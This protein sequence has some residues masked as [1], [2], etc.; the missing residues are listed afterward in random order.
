[1]E[2]IRTN[3]RNWFNRKVNIGNVK[4]KFDKEGLAE[5]EQP[6]RFIKRFPE[7]IFLP[8]NYKEVEG[9]K[10]LTQDE[11]FKS[12]KEMKEA[13]KRKDVD[14]SRLKNKIQTLEMDNTKWKEEVEKQAREIK[15]MKESESEEKDVN[16][17]FNDV[18]S[19]KTVPE[20]KKILTEIRIEAKEGEEDLSDDQ[21]AEVE[22]EVSKLQPKAKIV[23]AILEET[24][25]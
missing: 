14:I 11:K 8:E 21:K 2:K 18:L 1:M 20:L 9:H 15:I 16:S 13:L 19:E 10:E 25:E 6:K 24:K 22:R 4:V 3:K 17:E 23:E 7:N 5:V 12:L